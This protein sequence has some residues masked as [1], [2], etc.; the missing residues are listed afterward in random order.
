MNSRRATLPELSAYR[1]GAPRAFPWHAVNWANV[2]I[3]A[4][5]CGLLCLIV[6]IAIIGWAG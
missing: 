2:Y 4:G 5:L 3:G 6:F 1:D